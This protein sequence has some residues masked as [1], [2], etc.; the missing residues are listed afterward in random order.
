MYTKTNKRR[1]RLNEFN[2][3]NESFY[4]KKKRASLIEEGGLSYEEEGF[5][6]GYEDGL[7]E[8]KEEVE[9]EDLSWI[10]KTH[11]EEMI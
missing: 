4:T 1:N 3:W 8:I 10:H 5:M 6:K 7:K 11:P 9:E 2:N